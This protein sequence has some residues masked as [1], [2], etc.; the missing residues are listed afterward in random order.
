MALPLCMCQHV[1]SAIAPFAY[2]AYRVIAQLFGTNAREEMTDTQPLLTTTGSQLINVLQML[3]DLSDLIIWGH[4]P[5]VVTL[6]RT[7]RVSQLFRQMCTERLA[8]M[9]RPLAF[10]RAHRDSP[11]QAQS[12][13]LAT[14][15][16][17]EAPGWKGIVSPPGVLYPRAHCMCISRLFDWVIADTSDLSRSTCIRFLRH[18]ASILM[19]QSDRATDPTGVPIPLRCALAIWACLPGA[20]SWSYS[21]TIRVADL[22][23]AELMPPPPLPDS[24]SWGWISL[25]RLPDGRAVMLGGPEMIGRVRGPCLMYVLARNRAAWE[26]VMIAHAARELI[27]QTSR[28]SLTLLPTGIIALAQNDWVALWRP[29]PWDWT[30]RDGAG[31]WELLPRLPRS[32]GKLQRLCKLPCGKLVVVGG[33]HHQSNDL[34]APGDIYDCIHLGDGDIYDPSTKMWT[35]LPPSPLVA[36]RGSH[37]IVAAVTGGVLVAG[38]SWAQLTGTQRSQADWQAKRYLIHGARRRGE[39]NNMGDYARQS[40]M[41]PVM[42]T[43][44]DE[45]FDEDTKKWYTLPCG[46]PLGNCATCM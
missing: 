35:A 15:V 41:Y 16:W 30:P 6:W 9:E 10:G 34:H 8:N 31:S 36:A 1:I 7:R 14:L 2:Q 19:E 18:T 24:G 27:D 46:V 45:I 43:M 39:L 26:E 37:Y 20:S 22:T 42:A 21:G 25:V 23:D 5:S 13:N 3:P 44:N 29:P 11:F 40:V 33:N 12:L 28:I 17:G 32:R 38:S 4:G